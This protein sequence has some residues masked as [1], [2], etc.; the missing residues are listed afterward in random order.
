MEHSVILLGVTVQGLR[1]PQLLAY[2]EGQELGFQACQCTSISSQ[3]LQVPGIGMGTT[4]ALHSGSKPLFAG[5]ANQQPL[6]RIREKVQP[7]TLLPPHEETAACGSLPN[8][9]RQQLVLQ[10]GAR[11]A[12]APW[13]CPYCCCP[14]LLLSGHAECIKSTFLCST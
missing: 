5:R 13:L 2:E 9:P 3:H 12:L 1:Q 4:N 11:L 10:A 6:R 14:R 7:P 8:S